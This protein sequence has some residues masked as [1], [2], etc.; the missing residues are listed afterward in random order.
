M[1]DNSGWWCKKC[2]FWS[3]EVVEGEVQLFGTCRRRAP[4]PRSAVD[5]G[6]QRPDRWAEW[7]LTT[8][9]DW[10]GEFNK[11]AEA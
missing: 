9:D 4:H 11:R 10:C 8:E 2:V 1:S 7:P 6:N 3:S 5:T